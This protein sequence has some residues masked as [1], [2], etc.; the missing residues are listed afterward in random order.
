M[1]DVDQW[2]PDQID[3]VASAL[4]DRARTGGQ[5]AQELRGLHDMATWQGE[6]GDAAKHAIEKSATHLETSAQNDFL[7]SMATKKA[8]QDV[9]S[10]KNDLKAIVDYAAAQPAIPI[11]LETNTVTKPDTTGWDDD[12]IKTLNDKIAELEDRIVAVLAAA[13]E[14]RQ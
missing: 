14:N 11:N 3:E 6:A 8:A 13:N 10:V 4:A 1:A 12:D 7:T 5:T 9:S 2:Q